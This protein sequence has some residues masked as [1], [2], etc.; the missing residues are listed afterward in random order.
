MEPIKILLIEDDP[1]FTFT[2]KT[3]LEARKGFSFSMDS[4]SDLT[5]GLK[6]ISEGNI[7]VILL[8]L[9]LKDSKGLDTI[10][11][12]SYKA[13]DLPIIVLTGEFDESIGQ[14]TLKLGAQDYFLKG[15]IH[16]EML[17][18]SIRYSMERKRQELALRRA[19]EDLKKSDAENQKLL[20]L[21]PSVLIRINFKDVVTHWNSVAERVLGIPH[22]KAID[23]PLSECG[24]QWNFE[25][26][27]RGIGECRTKRIPLYLDDIEFT[28]PDGV[29]RILG[30]TV[31]PIQ[32]T[33]GEPV[34]ILI[35]G[36]DVT[37]YRSKR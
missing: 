35:F 12:I 5:V 4:A 29:K 22:A 26:L 19:N 20:N 9:N 1:D 2:L 14:E 30:V 21:I 15:E 36:A 24:A 37:D 33:P 25:I 6:K 8:D 16:P 17:I 7:D 32:G 23:R 34:G 11:K 10:R 13:R 18:R 28:R 3:R 27:K 31:H